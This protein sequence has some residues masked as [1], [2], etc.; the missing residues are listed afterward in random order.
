MAGEFEKVLHRRVRVVSIPAAIFATAQRVMTP[1]AP[2]AAN[3]MAMNHLIASTETP[4][5]TTD[6]IRD[7]GLPRLRTVHQ[8]LTDRATL[9]T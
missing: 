8:I 7:L 9:P 2:S 5:D 3:V 1:F 6:V 4:W